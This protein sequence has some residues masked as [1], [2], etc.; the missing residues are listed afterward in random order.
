M[1]LQITIQ[2][3]TK[4]RIFHTVNR[5]SGPKNFTRQIIKGQWRGGLRSVEAET[6]GISV[7]ELESIVSLNSQCLL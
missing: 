3:P 7:Y 4:K 1:N 5:M 6:S 2:T